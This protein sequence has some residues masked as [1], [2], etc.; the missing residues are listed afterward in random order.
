VPVTFPYDPADIP[1]GIAEEDLTIAYYDAAAGD[2][3][4]LE[5]IIVD[6]VANTISG[7]LSHFT[8]FAVVSAGVPHTVPDHAPGAMERS[9]RAVIALRVVAAGA[10]RSIAGAFLFGGVGLGILFALAPRIMGYLVA[11]VCFAVAVNA[12]RQFR[13]RRRQRDE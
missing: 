6:T 3:V 4:V 2:W 9:R 8:A 7:E 5:G 1:E 10:R 13:V 11:L 12:A